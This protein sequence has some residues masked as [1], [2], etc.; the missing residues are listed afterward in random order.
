MTISG[1]ELEIPDKYTQGVDEND[2]Q[3]KYRKKIERQ[4]SERIQ[5]SEAFDNVSICRTKQPMMILKVFT[6]KNQTKTPHSIRN[7]IYIIYANRRSSTI[8][9]LLVVATSNDLASRRHGLDRSVLHWAVL[10]LVGRL[11]GSCIAGYDRAKIMLSEIIVDEREAGKFL[12]VDGLDDGRVD[13]SQDRFF[14]CEV[15]VEVAHI[16]PSFL[17]QQG[18]KC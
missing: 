11:F 7:V 2:E 18:M 4:T 9:A 6:K 3:R 16:R 15:L 12:L 1:I 17:V 13:R 10:R 8:G 5:R 14:G